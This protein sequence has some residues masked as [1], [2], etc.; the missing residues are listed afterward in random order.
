MAKS[1][2]T[3]L[4]QCPYVGD[5]TTNPAARG[6]PTALPACEVEAEALALLESNIVAASPDRVSSVL[7]EI[8]SRGSYLQTYDELLAGARLAWRNHSRCV[9]R[10]IWHTLELRDA[11]HV[12]T[13]DDVAAE[14]ITHLKES[15]NGGKLRPTITVFAEPDNGPA[16]S[17]VNKQLIGYAGYRQEDRCI[18]D[19]A[20]ADLT[21]L[22]IEL[23][24]SA[25]YGRFDVLPLIL[26][27]D[28]E[29][30][31]YPVPESA[32]LR[33]ALSHPDYPQ[34]ADLGLTW[35]A[36]PAVSNMILA[37][38][39]LRY[40]AAPFTGWF[41]ATEIGAR[42]LVDGDRYDQLENVADAVGLSRGR[43]DLWRDRAMVILTEAVMH[44]FAQAGVTITDHHR[45]GRQFANFVNREEKCGRDVPTDWSWVN[46]PMSAS[47]VPTFHRL[48]VDP[49]PAPVPNFFRRN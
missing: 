19:P 9:G 12:R 13:A 40:P 33:I 30:S 37:S 18:G 17:I 4:V 10:A 46:P 16:I 25:P 38:G 31:W 42:D 11:R 24:W 23:G 48:Y 21:D 15:T 7:A 36:N 34:I 27:V 28:G 1:S 20:N 2:R 3:H 26:S 5:I 6:M 44:S 49:D 29:L 45:V 43:N 47:A 32:V 41:V 39:G 14:C 8:R 35:H 22:A